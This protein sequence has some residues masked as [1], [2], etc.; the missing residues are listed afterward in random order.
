MTRRRGRRRKKLLDDL[1]DRRGY[2]HL[3]EELWLA[4]CGGIVLEEALDLSSD[5]LLNNNKRYY[6]EKYGRNRQVTDDNIIRGVRFACWITNRQE[7]TQ[8]VTIPAFLANNGRTN[9]PPMLPYT[10]IA[11]LVSRLSC[12]YYFRPS[13]IKSG[14]EDVLKSVLNDYGLR[15]NRRGKASAYWNHS[16]Q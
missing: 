10:Y 8:H 16:R 6:V 7:N 14:T 3:K 12:F 13:S 15:A 1:K 9:A 11:S 5:R 2:S 4:L